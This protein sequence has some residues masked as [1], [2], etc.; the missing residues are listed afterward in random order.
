MS[1]CTPPLLVSPDKCIPLPHP[2][3]PLPPPF[4]LAPLDGALQHGA[5]GARG[6]HRCN[7]ASTL[8]C[9][10]TRAQYEALPTVP[11][12][13]VAC[14]A[15]RQ[16]RWGGREGW[17]SWRRK[18]D[19]HLTPWGPHLTPILLASGYSSVAGV[20]VTGQAV[21][22]L[23]KCRVA[24]NSRG[25]MVSDEARSL[26]RKSRFLSNWHSSLSR[27][28]FGMQSMPHPGHCFF[29]HACVYWVLEAK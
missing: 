17:S 2:L 7:S 8:F 6:Q 23:D 5:A 18:T 24:H 14:P 12:A 25:L 13:V 11:C 21:V 20:R 29:L 15:L 9:W 4:S 3:F 26:V 27:F 10:H 19:R 16:R 22:V 28:P 1:S